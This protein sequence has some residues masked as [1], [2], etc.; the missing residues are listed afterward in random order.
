[1]FKFCC[2]LLTFCFWVIGISSTQ[3]TAAILN[4]VDDAFIVSTEPDTPHGT[5]RILTWTAYMSGGRGRSLMKFS[6]SG[7]PDS[8]Q[9][10]SATLYLY[11]YDAGGFV[12]N[13]SI[14]HVDDD[15]W[16]EETL[17][18]NNT[19]AFPD[20]IIHKNIGFDEGWVSF[21]LL[22]SGIWNYDSDLNDGYVSFLIKSDETGDERHNFYSKEEDIQGNF[23][24]YLEI[25][26][27]PEPATLALLGC[28][29]LGLLRNRK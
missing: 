29:L 7:M 8:T 27:I 22:A 3:A 14:Y 20:Q 16:T 25:L 5:D 18:W 10:A 17:T 1:M 23:V 11:Q 15:T 13:V 26:T 24:P 28:G 21:D 19:P 12:P 6:L 9:L 4:P 2:F